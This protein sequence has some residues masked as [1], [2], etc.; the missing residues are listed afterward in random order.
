VTAGGA[1]GSVDGA[2]QQVSSLPGRHGLHLVTFYQTHELNETK[3]LFDLQI[4][5]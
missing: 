5:F 2:Q 4:K 1:S 3:A